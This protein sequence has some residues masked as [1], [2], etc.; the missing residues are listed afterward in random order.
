MIELT[1]GYA[2]AA[3]KLSPEHRVRWL[4]AGGYIYQRPGRRWT[5]AFTPREIAAAREKLVGITA[6][7]RLQPNER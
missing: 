1:K 7:N 4:A 3:T 5:A 6:T 2:E